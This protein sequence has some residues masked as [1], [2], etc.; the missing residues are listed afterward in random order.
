MNQDFANQKNIEIVEK[1]NSHPKT[2]SYNELYAKLTSKYNRTGSNRL[3]CT[4]FEYFETSKKLVKPHFDYEIFLDQPD[5]ALPSIIRTNFIEVANKLFNAE[6]KDWAIADDSRFVSKKEKDINGKTKTVQ[7]Y[8]IS[9]HFVLSTKK[10]N[11]E[12]FGSFVNENM[13]LFQDANLHGIDTN[14]YRIGINKFRV[15]M[16]KKSAGDHESL[17][18][19]L[20]YLN[21]ENFHKHLITYVEDCEEFPIALS[22]PVEYAHNDSSG[23]IIR[24]QIQLQGQNSKDEIDS[25][26]NSYNIISTK[27]GYNEF[28]GCIFYD[29][30]KHECG[31]THN[32]NHN[33]LIHNTKNNTLKLKCHSS[34]CK[35]FEKILYKEKAPTLHFNRDYFLNIPIKEDTSDN[36]DEVKKY[37]EQFFIFI[38]DTNSYYRKRFEYNQ[39]YKYYEKELKAINISGYDDLF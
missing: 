39:K 19:P 8:K 11:F 9:M 15:P 22:N 2:V 25:I 12:K 6:S 4:C 31:N 3:G 37:F 34:R 36:Y 17:L 5:G 18:T 35:N 38:R 28:E 33:F 30:Q 1:V 10:C 21:K 14:I 16:T 27:I 23:E 32:N 26:I 24:K 29:I 13:K 7:K 20:N